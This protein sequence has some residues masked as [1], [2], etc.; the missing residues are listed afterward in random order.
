[1]KIRRPLRYVPSGH[2][3]PS[4]LSRIPTGYILKLPL[5]AWNRMAYDIAMDQMWRGLWV[6]HVVLKIEPRHN[7]ISI[8][9]GW[10]PKRGAPVRSVGQ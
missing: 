3:L 5:A 8:R 6:F 9:W 10:S 4:G 1:M 7:C 2:I